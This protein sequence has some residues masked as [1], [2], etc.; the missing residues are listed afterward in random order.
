VSVEKMA[1]KL[2]LKGV[3]LPIITPFKNDAKKS[4]DEKALRKLVNYLIDEQKA[5]GLVPC[6]T[7]GEV[8]V[9]S[10]EEH[11][12]VLK[13]VIDETKGRVP[14][15]AGAGSNNTEHAIELTKYAEE[16]GA[17]ATLQVS[18]YYNRPSQDGIFEHFKV[19]ANAS[20]LPIVLYNIPARTGRNIEAKTIIRLWKE[21]PNII[22][23]KD[24]GN[25]NTQ[26]EEII[27]ATKGNSKPFYILAGEDRNTYATLCLGGHGA[28]LAVGHVVGKEYRQMCTLMLEK[29]EKNYQE[30]ALEIHFR[31]LEVVKNLFLEPNPCPIKAAYVMMKVLENDVLRLPL[32]SMTT[33][34]KEKLAKSLKEL[35]KIK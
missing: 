35:G 4:V 8:P 3:Y 19:I 6:G 23:L 31:T 11:K 20:K 18:P 26:L 32:L 10:F 5:D 25:D 27:I 2:V 29:K 30:K 9:L 34:G 7:T 33:E 13:I 15:I 24:A 17:A 28:I 1:D 21:I 14:I 12:L 16:I 22:A